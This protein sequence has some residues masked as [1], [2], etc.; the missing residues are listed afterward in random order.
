MKLHN[1]V[2]FQRLVS[3]FS[4]TLSL[5]HLFVVSHISII[6]W[7]SDKVKENFETNLK[8][9]CVMQLSLSYKVFRWH[10][11]HEY[12]VIASQLVST[13]SCVA[14]F[15]LYLQLANSWPESNFWLYVQLYSYNQII[16][17]SDWP[18]LSAPQMC[19]LVYK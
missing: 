14:T 1:T 2:Y 11:L 3:Q 12:H 19:C 17:A 9:H 10:P 4:L 8:V 16:A 18:C 5:G 15:L 6:R 13:L 7:P